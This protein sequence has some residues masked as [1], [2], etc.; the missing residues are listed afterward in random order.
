MAIIKIQNAVVERTFSGGKGY[1]VAETFTRRDGE[2]GKQP[3]TL[4]FD[5]PQ[6]IPIG[7][8]GAFSGLYSDKIEEYEKKDGTQGQAI[9]RNINSAKIDGELT[10]PAGTDDSPF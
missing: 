6:D 9:R 5:E 3:F 10:L 1:A 7:A 8:V 2:E 4:W